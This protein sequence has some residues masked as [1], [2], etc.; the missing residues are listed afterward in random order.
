MGG[1]SAMG[2]GLQ[3]FFGTIA[4]LPGGNSKVCDGGCLQYNTGLT[5]N[6]PS[7]LQP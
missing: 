6:F 7:Q 2:E 5:G 3:W 4:D 1:R